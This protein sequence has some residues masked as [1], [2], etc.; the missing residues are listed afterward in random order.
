MAGVRV[1]SGVVFFLSSRRRHMRY[2]GDW[3]SDVCSSDLPL[4]G[5]GKVQVHFVRPPDFFGQSNKRGRAVEHAEF[6]THQIGRA[7]CRER[8]WIS[9]A[10]AAVDIKVMSR[11]QRTAV[12]CGLTQDALLTAC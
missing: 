10:D 3:S 6:L 11:G 9:V 8:V 4:P 1:H 2:I 7:S 12:G 5:G